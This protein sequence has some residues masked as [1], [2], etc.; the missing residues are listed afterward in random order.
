MHH[1]FSDIAGFLEPRYMGY[2]QKHFNNLSYGFEKIIEPFEIHFHFP[3]VAWV[4]LQ[5]EA[6]TQSTGSATTVVKQQNK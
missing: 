1:K 2:I 4:H 5:T 6:L 3:T